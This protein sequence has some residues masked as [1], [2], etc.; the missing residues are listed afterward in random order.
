[1]STSPQSNVGLNVASSFLMALAAVVLII[2]CL[3]IA[4]LLLARGV[5]RRREIAVR[6]AIGGGRGRIVRQ[7]L[8]EG[9]VLAIGGAAL[10]MVIGSWSNRVLMQSLAAVMP[11]TITFD[12]SADRNVMIVT[13]TTAVLA[14]V[15]FALGPALRTVRADVIDDLK[16][17]ALQGAA[18]QGRRRFNARNVLVAGQLALSLTLLCTG[19]LFARGALAAA[20]ADPGFSYE[21]LVLANVDPSMAG[22]DD[23]RVREIQRAALARL[24]TIPGV[25]AVAFASTVPF[26][27]LHEGMPVKAAGAPDPDT[28]GR[29]G[30]FRVIGADYFQALGL[31]MLRGREFTRAEEESADAPRVAIIDELFARRLFPDQDPI[32][33][34]I[35]IVTRGREIG[36]G[37]D[38]QPMEIVGIAPGLRD[39]LF[40][41]AP[42]PHVYVPW[43]RNFRAG[44]YLYVRTARPG[45][46]A[47]VIATVRKELTQVD[48]GLPILDLMA[49]RD[50]HAR[51][52]ELWAVR[53]GGSIVTIVG[54]LALILAV[55]GIY[56][57]KS[58]LVSQRTREI[59]V[60]IAV[61][62]RPRDV[63]WMMLREG[64]AL[65]A[66]GLAIGLILS[67]VAGQVL[68][69][70]LYQVS[71]LDPI[72]FILAPTALA[73]SALLAAFF[74]ARRAT[75]VEPLTALRT[76]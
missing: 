68:S 9:F 17:N 46:D 61:G 72:V 66:T 13:L 49:M 29:S 20:S 48:A 52:L 26:G 14:T 53:T 57:V 31:P 28:P 65:T 30:T 74:P 12:P 19:G 10:G 58:F 50:F 62:A 45:A 71:P 27:D 36:T 59:G 42:V 22:Y 21:Q 75:R 44:G 64:M 1:M 24:R 8:T 2:A 56:G 38:G 39:T 6:V 73:V 15:L 69:G 16:G 60:R 34:M 54:A 23:A 33:Q 51:S 3:N 25:T 47:D 35:Q 41:Q 32:G 70:M 76:E 40:D 37:N 4:N 55:A 63:L 5:A 18:A 11:L 43:G 67:T 7:L